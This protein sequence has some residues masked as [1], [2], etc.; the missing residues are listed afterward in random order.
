MAGIYV[1]DVHN[2]AVGNDEWLVHNGH[3]YNNLHPE[4][5]PSVARRS[6]TR[7][8]QRGGKWV[9]VTMNS[10]GQ[11]VTRS[12]SGSYDF[13]VRNGQIRVLKSG[14]PISGHTALAGHG[15]VDFAGEL[16][17]SSG[18]NRGAL[19]SW[20]NA[21]GHFRPSADDAHLAG[22]PIELFRPAF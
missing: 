13:V 1:E 22:L 3:G 21:S 9:T 15:P 18:N 19:R 10:R 14:S 2:Y 11:E 6:G 16:R 12:A 7:L 5:V 4:D 8:E 20:N 17:F